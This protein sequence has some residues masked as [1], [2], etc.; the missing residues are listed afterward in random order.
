MIQAREAIVQG[1]TSLGIELGSTRIK[2]ILISEEHKPIASGCYEWE[3]KLENNIWTYSLEEI[4]KGV[5]GSYS[6]LLADIKEKH[7]VSI[8]TIGSIGISGMMHGYMVFDNQ[9]E[10]LVPFRTWRNTITQRASKELSELFNFHIPQRWSIAHL[11]EALL[12]D[13]EHVKDITY[14]T[15]L[16]GYIHWKLTGKNVLGIGEASGVFPINY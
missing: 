12:N 1:K 15:T 9:G 16:A 7:K 6:A 3:N 13:E 4:W 8:E 2:A 11:Y 10:L 14:M 5:Q